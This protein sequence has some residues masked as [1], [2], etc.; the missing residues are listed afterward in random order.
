MAQ[1][2]DLIVNGSAN[3]IG[4]IY[5]DLQGNASS[6]TRLA[7]ARTFR[8]NLGSTS[9]ASFDGSANITP[10]VTGTLPI[11]NGGTGATTAAAA[12]TAFGLTATATELNYCDGVT[13]NIQTQLN[14][15]M[16]SRPTCIELGGS[17]DG[18]LNEGFIN[19]HFNGSTADYTSRIIESSQ[20]VISVNGINFSS[21][22]GDI[23]N[24]SYTFM[25]LI[26]SASAPTGAYNVVWYDTTNKV[27][28]FWVNGAWQGMNTY[29]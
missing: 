4:T 10:G 28:K 7:N 26:Q 22:S 19:F 2:R 13:S 23:T 14:G 16:S 21:S 27:L 3:I 18:S 17:A 15:K 11:A 12:L 6:A 5:G 24:G 8:T 25:K 9:T 20:G 1:V 29:Q